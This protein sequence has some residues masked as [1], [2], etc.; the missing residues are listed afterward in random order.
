MSRSPTPTCSGPD[1]PKVS[2]SQPVLSTPPLDQLEHSLGVDVLYALP[3]DSHV[4]TRLNM[5]VQATDRIL[6]S[7]L[8]RIEHFFCSH[9]NPKSLPLHH[10]ISTTRPRLSGGQSRQYVSEFLSL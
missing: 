10:H 3:L 2:Q 9:V 5:L 6:E 1:F 7:A 8:F 4:V